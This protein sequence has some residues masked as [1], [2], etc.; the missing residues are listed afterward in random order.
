MKNEYVEVKIE[1][2]DIIDDVDDYFE[3]SYDWVNFSYDEICGYNKDFLKGLIPTIYHKFLKN[4]EIQKLL[5]YDIVRIHEHSYVYSMESNLE[6]KIDDYIKDTI[7]D[8]L[9]LDYVSVT[10]FFN[11]NEEST[12]LAWSDYIIV[13]FK[14]LDYVKFQRSRDYWDR[15]NNTFED[16]IIEI[17]LVNKRKFSF[18]NLDASYNWDDNETLKLIWN[19]YNETLPAINSIIEKKRNKL[20]DLINTHVSILNVNIF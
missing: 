5:E 11:N 1:K 2:T 9:P 4:E 15:I 3:N 8:E 16:E 18:D 14:R 19:D 12:T 6:Q 17:I 13:K 20:K 7:C 10:G